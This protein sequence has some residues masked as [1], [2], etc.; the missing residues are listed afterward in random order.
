MKKSL[1]SLKVSLSSFVVT[2][3]LILPTAVFATDVGGDQGS[4]LGEVIHQVEANVDKGND[5]A[6]MKA[7]AKADLV[8]VKALAAKVDGKIR[9]QL[10]NRNNEPITLKYAWV[11]SDLKK[12]VTLAANE[13]KVIELDSA[14][15]ASLGLWVN[16]IAKT[17]VQAFVE[18][19]ASPQVKADWLSV[20]PLVAS[21]D[22]KLRFQ[23]VNNGSE[24]ITVKY[25]LAGSDINQELDLAANEMKVIEIDS[26][27]DN[28][29]L[30]VW[31]N[32]VAIAPVV[33]IA[34]D[35]SPQTQ[36]DLV[37]VEAL[38]VKEVGKIRFQL[39]NT[40]ASPIT[41]KYALAGSD[42][43][44]EID[45]AAKETAIIEIESAKDKASLDLWV[46]EVSKTPVEAN[47]D[48]SVL[49]PDLNLG[50]NTDTNPG[51]DT[52]TT[53]G[54]GSGLSPGTGTVGGVS[55]GG[56]TDNGSI[57]PTPVVTP[58]SQ[59]AGAGANGNQPGSGTLV[60]GVSDNPS[61]VAG[62]DQ[63]PQTG[64]QVPWI[65]YLLGSVMVLLGALTVTKLRRR[66]H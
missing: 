64:E 66:T 34:A 52:G 11:G 38:P 62:Y 17:P 19:T 47:I 2:G 13:K 32:E 55:T 30:N 28:A 24:P 29:S 50:N 33:A 53:P 43:K 25:A 57:T 23:C 1:K 44:K 36:A 37:I 49:N 35:I 22:G 46:N 40:N 8:F 42:L 16:E 56:N 48:L 10:E 65:Y 39:V 58:D 63:L 27:R 59:N 54:T 41:L 5:S 4:K 7:H 61:A 6:E 12:D 51:A 15:K 20:R 3:M 60:A 31:V 21:I 45:L 26:A 14:G 18:T 9:Y